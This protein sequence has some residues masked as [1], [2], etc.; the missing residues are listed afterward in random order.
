MSDGD[1]AR[2]ESAGLAALVID[3]MDTIHHL[4]VVLARKNRHIEKLRDAHVR[5]DQAALMHVAK[6]FAMRKT[7]RAW[8]GTSTPENQTRFLL[9]RDD[10]ERIAADLYDVMEEINVES[11]PFHPRMWSY[12]GGSTAI[13]AEHMRRL[14]DLIRRAI[15][16]AFQAGGPKA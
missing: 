16:D 10:I 12:T 8:L 13:V 15:K 7:V 1:R 2:I 5:R 9:T 4:N 3:K 11:K 6:L 14:P